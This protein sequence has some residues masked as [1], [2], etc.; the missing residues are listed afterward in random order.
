MQEVEPQSPSA[1]KTPEEL[2]EIE[3]N[4]YACLPDLADDQD[5][6]QWWAGQE[7]TLPMLSNLARK[8]LA[9]PASSVPSERIFSRG[10]LIVTDFRVCLTGNN[11]EILVL[12]SMNVDYLD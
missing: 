1:S 12:T 10:G 11:V 8:Y 9:I 7:A 2:L 3:Q 6:L 5:P 4:H